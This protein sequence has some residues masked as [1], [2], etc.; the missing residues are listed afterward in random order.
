MSTVKL[1]YVFERGIMFKNYVKIALRN[2]MRQKVFSAVNI[3]GLAI[4][5]TCGILLSLW[6]FDEVSYDKFHEN[7]ENI[8]RIL[9]NQSYSSQ[10]MQVAVTPVPLAES[11]KNDFPEIV[12]A[13]RYNS[14][15]RDLKVDDKEFSAIIGA[16]VDEDFFKMFS[17]PIIKGD[18]EPLSSINSIVIT[19]GTAKKLFNDEEAI[20]KNIS[21]YDNNFEVTA[22]I[23]NVQ[24]NSHLSFEYLLPFQIMV[25]RNPDIDNWGSNS[26]YTYIQLA[27]KT[28]HQ[29]FSEKITMYLKEQAE[30]A[31]SELYLQPIFKTHLHSV[32]LVADMGGMGDFQYIILFS[33]ISI[34]IIIISSVNFISLSTAR[35]TKRA[36]EVGLRKVVGSRRS[37]LIWQ[38]LAE[39]MILLLISLV[40]GLV[41]VE[42]FLPA[43]NNIAAKELSLMYLLNPTMLSGLIIFVIIIGFLTGIYPAF[44]LSSFK[45]VTALKG[46]QISGSK[47]SLFRKIMVVTQWSLSIILIISTLM[48]SKQLQF[49][50]NK[51][52]GFEKEQI[53]YTNIGKF[54][55]LDELKEELL[56]NPE[57]E[58]VSSTMALPHRIMSSTSGAVW[59]GK[60]EDETFLVHYNIVNYD[61]I[62]TFK[63]EIA[64]GRSF[65]EEFSD[66]TNF[67]FI[68]N[69]EA[70]RQMGLKD[71]I[72]KKFSIW[73][74]D[75]K[76]VGVMKDFH[77]KSLHDPIEPMMFLPLKQYTETLV[78][79]IKGAD[80]ENTI[81]YLE[82]TLSA[83]D[84]G[85]KHEFRFF[86]ERYDT[87]YR[88]E[89][90]MEMILKMFTILA[91]FIACLGLFGLSTFMTQQ[92]IKE[93]GIRK[94]LGA[95]VPNIV[96]T[97]SK[98]FTRWIIIA[99]IIA[100][101]LAY[102]IINKLLQ[103]FAYRV[104]MGYNVFAITIISSILIAI[105]TISFQTIRAA[106][107][108]PVDALK[109]E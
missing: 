23:Q 40:I 30:G 43:F 55:K 27:D 93:I 33:I 53:V 46:T 22:I 72:D 85:K 1:K 105:V 11:I 103:N 71:P 45:P 3:I 96:I 61:F 63:I 8:Y 98:D 81:Y 74:M 58:S 80:T 34:F 42:L 83:F 18:L 26:T 10:S 67:G 6:I 73:G 77:F 9:E 86:D 14:Y 47:G 20:G 50:K 38:F 88:A 97:L 36:K 21:L 57:V 106:N 12:R 109:Y 69:Q 35:Y 15:A 5:L 54:E 82:Q 100:C 66:D 89:Q 101:P 75:G 28:S 56:K 29:Q 52:L 87:M 107:S 44:L 104:D 102:Y 70:I 91:I 17:F 76:I 13:T 4:G 94:V 51:K 59:E 19:E 65:S 16:F 49:M 41:M 24:E 32:G 99:N 79:R 31:S 62:E 7:G 92:R 95:D 108:N 60:P 90:Q 68:L 48:I 84:S 25:D 39:S 64:E 78:I 2:L 37:Q